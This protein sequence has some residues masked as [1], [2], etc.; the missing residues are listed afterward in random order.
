MQVR[1][2]RQNETSFPFSGSMACC[3]EAF[4][5]PP[6][7]DGGQSPPQNETQLIWPLWKR[8][9]LI[10]FDFAPEE[11]S[12]ADHKEYDPSK[13][14]SVL[15]RA[16]L[17]SLDLVSVTVQALF[18]FFLTPRSRAP[19]CPP[20]SPL[21]LQVLSQRVVIR[22]SLLLISHHHSLTDSCSYSTSSHPLGFHSLYFNCEWME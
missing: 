16:R 14:S 20:S 9:A 4:S 10:S 13:C 22:S 18:V 12:Y 19:P 1:R 3:R 15:S 8:D 21:F 5:F 17:Y 11:F 2:W 6:A 7:A